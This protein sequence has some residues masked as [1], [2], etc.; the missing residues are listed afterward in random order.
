MG[1]LVAM[2]ASAWGAA[3]GSLNNFDVVNDTGSKCYGFEIELDDVHS[4]DIT[5]T[6]DYNHYGIPQ[7]T[8]D[9][10]D[11]VHPKTYIRYAAKKSP[12]GQYL[13]CTNPDL[14]HALGP[15]AGHAFT[16]PSINV[17]GEHFGAGYIL[18]P[19]L[20]KYHWLVDDP[21]NPGTLILG[22]VVN[23]ATP[24]FTYIPPAPNPVVG[25]PPIPAQ[26]VAAV[27]PDPPEFNAASR[28]GTPYWVKILKTVQKKDRKVNLNEL[29][30]LDEVENPKGIPGWQG[31]IEK[32]ETEFEWLIFQQRPAND[33]KGEVEID[34]K[35]NLPDGDNTV[36]RRY[37][38]YTYEGDVDPENGE[39]LCSDLSGS[40]T[41]SL[42]HFIGA[43]M[44]GFNLAEPLGLI[45]HAPEGDLGVPYTD[46][47]LVAGG[48]PPYVLE[49]TAGALP[50]G[51]DL[52]LVTGV[53]SG[54]PKLVGVFPFTVVATDGNSVSVTNH[55]SVTIEGAVE[56]DGDVSV[57]RGGFR[58]NRTSGHFVQQVTI[59]NKGILAWN[60]PISLVLDNLSAG[61]SLDSLA[62]VTD[63]LPP[64]GSPYATVS[65]GADNILH[66]GQSA[67]ILLEFIDPLKTAITYTP[68]LLAGPGSR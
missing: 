12:S 63:L 2:S 11:P 33:A 44:A 51:L 31:D 24:S 16:N 9:K 23:L 17:G 50:S 4:T 40:C 7:I 60:G 62:G 64:A 1:I 30:P 58:F 18:A 20:V 53:L 5:Y 8:E 61:V 10:S 39:A 45:D 25:Q 49:I 22:P 46:R 19:S 41:N 35:D 47:T 55:Y 21:L 57:T 66:P 26:A 27:I 3:Y 67:S 59:K 15:T 13:S 56:L 14:T 32:P 6:Y 38:F 29:L 42:G 28:F 68:R 34:G 48:T 37:E 36:T 43:Q 65:V 52:N 54:T